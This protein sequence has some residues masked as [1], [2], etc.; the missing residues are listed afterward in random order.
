MSDLSETE[1]VARAQRGEA[2]AAGLLYEAHQAAIFRYLWLRLGERETAEDLTGEVFIR[3]LEA[4]PRYRPSATPFR[5]WLYRI[6]RNLAIDHG[7]HARRAG[8]AAPASLE[9]VPVDVHPVGDPAHQ[10]EQKLSLEAL[11]AAL[12]GLEAG[13]REVVTLRFLSGLSLRETA[14]V[15]DKTEAAVKALQHRGLAALNHCLNQELGDV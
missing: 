6:A 5:G 15:V 4:L 14:V 8:G 2:E 1:V 3:M 11:R 13:Q 9:T 7:R 10:T 12:A